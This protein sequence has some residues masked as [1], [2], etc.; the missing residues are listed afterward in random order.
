MSNPPIGFGFAPTGY[1]RLDAFPRPNCISIC[2]CSDLRKIGHLANSGD[3]DHSRGGR[4]GEKKT[5][6]GVIIPPARGSSAAPRPFD[7]ARGGARLP[8]DGA[9]DYAPARHGRRGLSLTEGSRSDPLREEGARRLV[10]H[11]GKN[12][13]GGRKTHEAER[14]SGAPPRGIFVGES[15]PEERGWPTACLHDRGFSLFWSVRQWAAD[16]AGSC[17]RTAS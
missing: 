8:D 10:L 4:G 14:S 5:S 1:A 2:R 11:S 9:V 16:A 15:V 3:A 7:Y 6:L 13:G 12:G 17:C